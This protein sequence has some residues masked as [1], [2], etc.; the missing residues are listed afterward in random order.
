MTEP[1]APKI[2]FPCDYPIH[3]IGRHS[4]TIVRDVVAVVRAHDDSVTPDSVGLRKSKKGRF[5]SVRITMRATGEEQL[6]SMHAELMAID[7]VKMVL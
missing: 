7:E 3:V 6:K 4:D 5:E 2:E 1:E